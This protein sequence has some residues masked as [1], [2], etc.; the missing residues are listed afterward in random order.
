MAVEFRLLGDIEAR[1]DERPVAVGHARQQC[2]LAAL[3][4]DAGRSVPA[5]QLIDRVWGERAP[6]RARG[7]LH[8]YLARLRRALAVAG[9]DIVRRPAGYLLDAEPLAVDTHRFHRLLAQAR[10]TDDDQ[11]AAGL[12]GQALE[13]WQGPALAGLDTPWCNMVRAQLDRERW[14][15]ELDSNDLALRLGRHSEVLAGL[16]GAAA[17]HPLDERLAGQWMLALYRSGRQAEALE[18]YQQ[19][20]AQLAEELGIEPGPQL[21]HLQRAVLSADPAL[22]P[23]AP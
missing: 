9:V 6:Q 19:A 16:V 8:T 13:L 4:V 5:D 14:A 22:A 20:R 15:A 11:V 17:A 23:P 2:V 1:V 3:L 10:S 12:V 7:T 18:V 21:Q